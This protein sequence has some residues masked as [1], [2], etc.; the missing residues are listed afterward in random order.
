MSPQPARIDPYQ[1]L[2]DQTIAHLERGVVPWR[3]PWRTS[4]GRPLNFHT[5]KPYH[6][7]NVLML[8]PITVGGWC[9][10]P[11]KRDVLP[12]SSSAGSTSP[13]SPSRQ[14]TE[15]PISPQ[16]IK[17]M[18]VHCTACGELWDTQFLRHELIVEA[19]VTEEE[20]KQWECLPRNEQLTPAI[21]Q[22]F[23]AVGFRF[24]RTLVNII[25]CDN[26]PA[27]AVASP[28]VMMVKAAFE[29]LLWKDEDALAAAFE[30]HGL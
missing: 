9:S 18:N 3:K 13:K 26:C 25:S 7:V 2:T 11:T 5:G 4:V 17:P 27:D 21:R 24:G 15:N 16:P 12:S 28:E 1:L 23:Q 29:A 20:I 14:Q 22:K 6:G 8:P 19:G 10:R 30:E